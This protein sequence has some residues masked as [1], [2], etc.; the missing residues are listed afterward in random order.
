MGSTL[1]FWTLVLRP[2]A[3][4]NN[5]NNCK[6]RL[7]SAAL[8]WRKRATSSAYKEIMCWIGLLDKQT[9]SVVACF[10]FLELNAK[11]DLLTIIFQASFNLFDQ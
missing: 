5:C 11:I 6:D 8:G 4:P 7:I 10:S 2:E 1:L 9:T 3:F